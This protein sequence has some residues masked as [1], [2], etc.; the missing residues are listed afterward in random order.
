MSHALSSHSTFAR[1]LFIS[2]HLTDRERYGVSESVFTNQSL[3]EF[4]V[5][6]IPPIV[7]IQKMRISLLGYL[8]KRTEGFM[9]CSSNFNNL[10]S[11]SKGAPTADIGKVTPML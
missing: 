5:A 4:S 7:R 2:S 6:A 10:I 3:S 1:V 8:C 11:I 9:D